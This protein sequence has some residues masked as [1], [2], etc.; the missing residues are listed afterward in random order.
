M[1]PLLAPGTHVL[2]RG[3][4]EVQVGLDPD[5]V[6]RP[7]P[8]PPRS[9]RG[10]HP[11]GWSARLASPS[12]TTG[13]C[14]PR[15]RRTT[16]RTPGR[17]T[18]LLRWLDARARRS[19]TPATAGAH[20]VVAV[21]PTGHPL[22][23]PLAAELAELCRRSGLRLRTRARPGPLP[24]GA[25]RPD[26]GARPGRRSASPAGSS[27]TTGSRDG[28]AP[29][30]RT[31]GRGAAPSSGRSW[32]RARRRACAAWTPTAP[33]R[34]RPGRCS[35]SSTR[36]ASAAR[37]RR[38]DPRAGRRRHWPRWPSAWAA[39]D[40]AGLRR[41]RHPRIVV[42]HGHARPAPRRGRSHCDGRR[43][44]TAAALGS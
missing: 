31:A 7:Y 3:P 24:R 4:H 13:R 6:G 9:S 10:L 37:P 42:Q 23:A 17:G 35:S 40:L 25:R 29:P 26:H 32:S 16:P 27:S 22:A 36:G 15:C 44:P 30:R 19:P 28:G 33:R 12:R 2:R 39:R 41:G 1:H 8:R 20:H 21:T 34:T 38:R 18:P 43:T 14:G 11:P 5:G